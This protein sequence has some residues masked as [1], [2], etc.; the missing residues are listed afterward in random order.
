MGAVFAVNH[1]NGTTVGIGGVAGGVVANDWVLTT[2]EQKQ[3]VVT[4]LIQVTEF[5]SAHQLVHGGAIEGDH[6]TLSTQGIQRGQRRPVACRAKHQMEDAFAHRRTC[7]HTGHIVGRT[8][9][10]VHDAVAI[11]VA[12]RL[13]L[14]ACQGTLVGGVGAV[15]VG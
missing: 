5:R 15:V 10:V 8:K 3:V 2:G 9:D 14:Q 1:K 11:N 7:G 12:R 4:V 6:T 13:N